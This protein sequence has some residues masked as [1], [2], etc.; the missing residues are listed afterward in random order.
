MLTKL[1]HNVQLCL[2]E[3]ADLTTITEFGPECSAISSHSVCNINLSNESDP[4]LYNSPHAYRFY[5]EFTNA[6]EH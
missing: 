1:T 6:I 2:R 4:A 3:E 5:S